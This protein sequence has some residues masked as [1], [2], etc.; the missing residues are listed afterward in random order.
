MTIYLSAFQIQAIRNEH[1]DVGNFKLERITFYVR[2]S[3]RGAPHPA[4]PKF[5]TSFTFLVLF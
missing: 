5:G 2:A 1:T 3:E 4:H